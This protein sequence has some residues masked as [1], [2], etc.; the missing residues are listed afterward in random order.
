MPAEYAV[1]LGATVTE[2]IVGLTFADTVNCAVA[3]LPTCVPPDFVTTV[4]VPVPFAELGIAFS[5]LAGM[6]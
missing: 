6:V 1:P 5:Q 3:A 4:I 2:P